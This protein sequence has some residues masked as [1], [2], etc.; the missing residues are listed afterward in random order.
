MA[1]TIREKIVKNIETTL[2]TISKANGYENDIKSVQRLLQSGQVV[3]DVPLLIIAEGDEDA[4]EGP[5]ATAILTLKRLG[6]FVV[7]QTRHDEAIDTRASDEILNTL[8]AD[9]EK[10]MMVDHTRGGFAIDTHPPSSTALDTEEGQPEIASL[11]QFQIDYRH[12]RQDPTSL[13]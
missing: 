10:A 3:T 11:M 4:E 9:V 8:R 1:D 5:L 6:V 12:A 7:V 2:K 13:T